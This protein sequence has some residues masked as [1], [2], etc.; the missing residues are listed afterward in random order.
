MDMEER[1]RALARMLA[2]TQGELA[3]L[4]RALESVEREAALVGVEYEARVG[5]WERRRREAAER[6]ARARAMARARAAGASLPTLDEGDRGARSAR[7]PAEETG[8]TPQA[9]PF[10]APRGDLAASACGDLRD[11][12]AQVLIAGAAV[13]VVRERIASLQS[14]APYCYRE[15]LAN[16]VA[17]N[18]RVDRLRDDIAGFETATAVY[19]R[20]MR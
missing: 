3:E 20:A 2:G 4:V 16:D 17:V 12:Q 14:S 8:R 9:S 7:L 10:S 13:S 11:L 6:F 1:P 19:E 5:C 15:W 18:E